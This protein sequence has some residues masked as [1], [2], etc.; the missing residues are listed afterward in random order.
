VELEVVDSIGLPLLELVPS[1]A[2]TI[3]ELLGPQHKSLNRLLKR[4]QNTC[5]TK[6]MMPHMND[7]EQ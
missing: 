3:S 1:A 7:I 4:L 2:P 6:T 5:S